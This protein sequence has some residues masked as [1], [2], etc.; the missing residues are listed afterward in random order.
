[1]LERSDRLGSLLETSYEVRVRGDGFIEDLDGD[2]SLDAR[3]ERAEDD[4]LRT[5]ENLFEESIA[6]KWH[7]SQMQSSVLAQD[8]PLQPDQFR[9]RVDP[10]F[11]GKDLPRALEGRQRIGLTAV[12]VEGQHEQRPQTFPQ[13]VA[14]EQSL[15]LSDRRTVV[16][17]RHKRPG[18]VLL[19]LQAKVVESV[20]FGPE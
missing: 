20:G 16:P 8:S 11:I 13:W 12:P 3:L 6:P 14:H 15:E 10:E 19:R 5:L 2:V 4:T 1:M 7:A 9:G 17:D 18:P